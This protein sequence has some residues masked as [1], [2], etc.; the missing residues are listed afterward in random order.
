MATAVVAALESVEDAAFIDAALLQTDR[1]AV[2]TEEE[3][4]EEEQDVA[5]SAAVAGPAAESDGSMSDTG[6]EANPSA[7]SVDVDPL[8]RSYIR[9]VVWCC[10]LTFILWGGQMLVILSVLPDRIIRSYNGGVS[11]DGHDADT[12]GCKHATAHAT[13]VTSAVASAGCFVTFLGS[14]LL[15]SAADAFGR[16]PPLIFCA[17]L[18]FLQ[19]AAMLGW[20]YELVPLWVYFAA[21]VLASF[22]STSVMLAYLSDVVPAPQRAYCFG[23]LF[24]TISLGIVVAPFVAVALGSGNNAPFLVAAGVSLFYLILVCFVPESLPKSK[25]VPFSSLRDLNP[26][27]IIGVLGRYKMFQRL[28]L[29]VLLGELTM[30]GRF[31]INFSY[32]KSRFHITEA[33]FAYVALTFGVLG[34]LSQSVLLKWLVRRWSNQRIMLLGLCAVVLNMLS[35]VVIWKL[36]MVRTTA[37]WTNGACRSFAMAPAYFSLSWFSVRCIRPIGVSD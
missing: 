8:T 17:V 30:R 13:L 10:V 37:A 27:R 9:S 35:F 25:R 28:A 18:N 5:A 2:S 32:L 36:W 20:V 26:F 23:L 7:V 24:A 16:R 31:A 21:N 11:C 3:E 6:I 29:V 14:P 4:E 12:P 33:Q 19:F 15:G 34:V 1:R 22:D